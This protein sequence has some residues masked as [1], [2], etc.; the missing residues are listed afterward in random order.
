MLGK[1]PVKLF[2]Q[3]EVTPRGFQSGGHEQ[4]AIKVSITTLLP[5]MKL[6]PI[7]KGWPIAAPTESTQD[8]GVIPPRER[9]ARHVQV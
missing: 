4:W 5:G 1:Q 6:G 2:L 7:F 8:H 9:P 3:G